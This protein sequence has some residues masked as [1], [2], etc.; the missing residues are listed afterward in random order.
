MSAGPCAVARSWASGH[1]SRRAT[2]VPT[3]LPECV[4]PPALPRIL[5]EKLLSFPG[6]LISPDTGTLP[7]LPFTWTALSL[8]EIVNTLF[9]AEQIAVED[10]IT[11]QF[12]SNWLPGVGTSR[13]AKVF[14]I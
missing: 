8:I 12:S 2:N 5:P 3:H 7:R 10:R 11:R 1:H 9:A 14:P 6:N 13:F 4:Q